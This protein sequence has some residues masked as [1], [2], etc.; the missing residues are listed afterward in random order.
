[1]ANWLSVIFDPFSMLIQSK[2]HLKACLHKKN[3][4]LTAA[5]HV[6]FPPGNFLLGMSHMNE[7]AR[8]KHFFLQYNVL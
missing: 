1:M 5:S 8:M 2:V 4:L 7:I 3:C 6:K